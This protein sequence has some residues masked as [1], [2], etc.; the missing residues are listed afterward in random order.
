VSRFVY[1]RCGTHSYQD[2]YSAHGSDAIF[3]AHEVFHTTNVIKYLGS[4]SNRPSSSTSAIT[5]KGLPSVTMNMNQTKNFLRQALT[6]RQMRVEIYQP[7]GGAAGRK[8]N[9]AWHLG[10]EA[11]PGNIA[12]LEDLLFDHSDMLSNA[13]SMAVKIQTKEGIR[14]VGCAFVDVQ[15]KMIGVT[16]YVEDD[17]FSNTEVSAVDVSCLATR[18]GGSKQVKAVLMGS[19]F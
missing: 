5:A 8:N 17:N 6:A 18:S 3:V 4:G 9:T 11:S 12:P 13:V 7:E 2:Y 19:P 1:C 15:D 16:E 10:K 14:T